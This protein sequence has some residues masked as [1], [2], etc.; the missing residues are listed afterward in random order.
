MELPDSCCGKTRSGLNIRQSKIQFIIVPRLIPVGIGLSVFIL[1]M[2][3]H[4]LIFIK[5]RHIIW[6]DAYALLIYGKDL[7]PSRQSNRKLSDRGKPAEDHIQNSR[8]LCIKPCGHSIQIRLC[9][10]HLP[11]QGNVQ[12]TDDLSP[13]FV[14]GCGPLPLR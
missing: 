8:L 4:I 5:A 6:A 2:L 1:Q 13:V 9:I 3:R 10:T 11:R 14:D 12:I 7:V